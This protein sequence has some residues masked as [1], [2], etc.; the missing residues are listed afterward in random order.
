[1]ILV[2]LPIGAAGCR[3]GSGTPTAVTGPPSSPGWE[4]R[5]NAALALARRG[6]DGVKDDRA[7]ETLQEMLN[8]EQQLRNFKHRT[9][10]NKEVPD[11]GAA[12][13][14]LIT[15]LQAVEELHRRRPELDIAGLKP[16][17]EKLVTSSSVA[18]ST[19]ARRTLPIFK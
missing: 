11:A 3:R 17:V 2:A 19:Q 6:S 5:Y 15:A 14:E 18:V 7:W 9:R 4:V 10:G 1:M 13:M 16:M 8:E 12:H